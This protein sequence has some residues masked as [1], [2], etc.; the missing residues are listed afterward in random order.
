MLLHSEVRARLGSEHTNSTFDGVQSALA[1][2]A[3]PRRKVQ[4]EVRCPR[5]TALAVQR[6]GGT[7]LLVA[8]LLSFAVVGL[9]FLLYVVWRGTRLG[10]EM[11]CRLCGTSFIL[12]TANVGFPLGADK[13]FSTVIVNGRA[14]GSAAPYKRC[15]AQ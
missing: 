3:V 1:G 2:A 8:T 6:R 13:P 4:S 10:D 7:R 9:P 12:N 15:V 11:V 5:C 14:H